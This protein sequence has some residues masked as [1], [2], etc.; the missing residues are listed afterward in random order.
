MNQFAA[1][2]AFSHHLADIADAL[3]LPAFNE[4]GTAFRTKADGSPVTDA[5]E[6]VERALAAE[7]AKAHPDDAVLG[8]EVGAVAGSR[9][10]RQWIVDGIDGTF[11]FVA[12]RPQ[13]STLI[14]LVLDGEPVVGMATFPALKERWWAARGAGALHNGRTIGTSARNDLDGAIMSMSPPLD[15]A[16]PVLAE[17]GEALRRRCRY[18]PWPVHPALAVAAGGVDLSL[19]MTGGPWDYAAPAVIVEEAGGRWTDPAG[20]R[21]LDAGGA[22]FTNGV[23]HDAALGLLS[24][25]GRP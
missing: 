10:R 7:V 4:N 20:G 23:L 5:D 9:G 22:L 18:T 21:R 11:N 13:W 3:S 8:E 12:G 14:A 15:A 24:T 2:L 1:D 16:P 19:H 25:A 17:A 6:A